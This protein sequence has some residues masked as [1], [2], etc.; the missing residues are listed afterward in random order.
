MA[1]PV[2]EQR[3]GVG[4]LD[5]LSRLGRREHVARQ[6][7]RILHGFEFGSRIAAQVALGMQEP[8]ERAHG[9][10]ALG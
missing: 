5:D 2:A 1:R 4:H 8:E 3:S 9:A 6:P 10:K 7:M